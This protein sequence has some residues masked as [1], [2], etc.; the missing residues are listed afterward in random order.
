MERIKS[1]CSFIFKNIFEKFFSSWLIA[2]AAVL[3]FQEGAISIEN[4]DV[5][6]FIILFFI[7]FSAICCIHKISEKYLNAILVLSV[8][9]FSLS[10]LVR[11]NNIYVFIVLGILLAIALYHYQNGKGKIGIQVTHVKEIIFISVCFIIFF[12]VVTAVSVL[13]YLNY[14]TPN[15]DFGIFCNMFHNMR[16]SFSPVT[17]CERDRLLSHFAVHFSPAVYIFLPFYYIFPSPVTV[18]VCQTVAIYSGL[19]P[20]VLIMKNRKIDSLVICLFSVVFMANTAFSM[21]CSYDFHENCLLVPFLMWMIY[22]YEKNKTPFV[23]L[24]ALLTLMVKEDA[25]IYVAVFAAFLVVSNKDW[26]RGVPLAVLA[27]A[28]FILAAWHINTYGLGIMSGRF[29]IMIDGDDGLFGIVKTVLANL[30]YTVS[31]IFTTK[32]GTAE[33]LIYFIQMLCPLGFIPLFTKKPSRLILV[34]PILLNL[35]TDYAYQYDI[36][37]QYGFAMTVLMMYVCVLDINDAPAEKKRLV[38]AIAA[39]LSVMMFFMCIIPSFTKNI[40]NSSENK[41]MYNEIDAV[42][43]GIDEDAVVCASTFFL[44]HL[45]QR[46]EIYEVHYTKHS[47]FDY[48]I[49]DYRPAYK[50]GSMQFAEKFKEY[51]YVQVDS[52]SEYVGMFV[53]PE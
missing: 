1:M 12:S 15:Y 8:L 11:S 31:M 53:R 29:D 28:Y 33:K 37:F 32:E 30:G 35:L 27:V 45:A 3:I 48:I 43:S 18:A 36:S 41:E 10:V 4:T 47:D 17:T 9:V 44:P 6:S 19:I 23:F 34:L 2:S 14:A 24:F 7:A 50:D 20:F 46:E 26:K 16:E 49:L 42:L 5:F 39:G 40:K 25:F 13:R 21:G 51:G 38:P 22:F 52:G